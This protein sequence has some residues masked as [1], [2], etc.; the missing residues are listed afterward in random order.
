MQCSHGVT[1]TAESPRDVELWK[2]LQTHIPQFQDG[3]GCR[4]D[5]FGC[6]C[7]IHPQRWRQLPEDLGI[8]SGNPTP[9]AGSRVSHF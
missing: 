2:E 9:P 8:A 4:A 7:N 6:P 3:K 1:G 5:H